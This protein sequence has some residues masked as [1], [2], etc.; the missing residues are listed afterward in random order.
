MPQV[1]AATFADEAAAGKG[2]ATIAARSA[3]T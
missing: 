1:I 2:L 3:A